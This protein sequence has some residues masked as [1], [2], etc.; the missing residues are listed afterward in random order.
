MYVKD[1]CNFLRKLPPCSHYPA[2]LYSCDVVSLYSNITHELGLTSLEYYI[3]IL[4]FNEHSIKIYQNVLLNI[5]F[6]FMD[7]GF[8]PWPCEADIDIFLGLLN[9]LDSSIKF[10]LGAS[11]EITRVDEGIVQTWNFLDI[12]IILF[13]NG[14]IETDIFYEETNTHVI[15]IYSRKLAC[16]HL[17]HCPENLQELKNNVENI[18][19][20]SH[21]L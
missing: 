10:T 14:K 20:N 1:D 8:I 11:K 9:D 2:K 15:I 5:F 19:Q 13:Q 18:Q 16:L 7:D 6:R 21:T 3:D 12:T 4:K 17:G